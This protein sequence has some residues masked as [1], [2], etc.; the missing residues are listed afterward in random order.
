[1]FPK[2]HISE[3]DTQQDEAEKEHIYLSWW[4]RLIKVSVISVYY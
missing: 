2:R 3:H 1:M 4:N